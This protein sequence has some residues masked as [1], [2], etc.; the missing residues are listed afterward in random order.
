[1]TTQLDT[2]SKI[3]A[4]AKATGLFK[5]IFSSGNSVYS[6][7]SGAAQLSGSLRSIAKLS[8]ANIPQSTLITLD[9]AQAFLA[10]GALVNDVSEG[11]K[12]FQCVGDGASAMAGVANLLV[13]LGIGDKTLGDTAGLIS[14]A[15]M[16]IASGGANV[17]ADISTVINL[18]N[19]ASDMEGVF[20]GDAQA[21]KAAAYKGLNSAV[22]AYVNTQISF[23]SKEAADYSAGKLN[24]FDF[25][26]DIG[27]NSPLAFPKFFPDLV[28]YFPSWTTITFTAHGESGGW[29]GSQSDTETYSLKQ[30]RI[31]GSDLKA[32][33]LDK[34]LVQPSQEFESFFTITPNI[35]IE[36]LSVI[37]MLLSTGTKGASKVTPKFDVLSA[38]MM[39]GVTPYILGDSWVFKGY[40]R[41]ETD[42]KSWKSTLPYPPLTL[43]FSKYPA[44]TGLTINGKIYR[45]PAETAQQ[46]NADDLKN[47]QIYLQTLDQNGDIETLVQIPEALAILKRW[48]RL[49]FGNLSRFGKMVDLADYWKC[50]SVLDV[51]QKS[52]FESGSASQFIAANPHY[53]SSSALTTQVNKVYQFM[54]MKN[55]NRL[56]RQNIANSMNIPVEKLAVGKNSNGS[57]YF[58]RSK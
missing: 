57:N 34:F 56:A 42:L 54:L 7:A 45:T 9:V 21:A 51:M 43:P 44:Q 41:N 49:T 5:K 58:Y 11:A 13:D 18:I 1:M 33:I 3:R 26:G 29:F 47:F 12:I 16:V 46:K 6:T 20:G 48:A 38:C 15:S 22:H 25:I 8:G 37:A 55:L 10:G 2:L 30:L 52:S 27:L 39:L 19:F 32:A 4:G 31:T 53:G 40:D 17:L 50:L 35:T 24:F 14:S 28:S 36:A 23:A